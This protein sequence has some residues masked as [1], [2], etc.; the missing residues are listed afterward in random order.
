MVDKITFHRKPVP[1]FK[2]PETIQGKADA[3]KTFTNDHL[4]R[5]GPLIV[6]QVNILA[7]GND[8]DHIAEIDLAAGDKRNIKSKFEIFRKAKGVLRGKIETGSF[9]LNHLMAV[10]GQAI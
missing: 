10:K 2:Q 8:T 9:F 4:E 3:G 5:P 1:L 7:V 6:D